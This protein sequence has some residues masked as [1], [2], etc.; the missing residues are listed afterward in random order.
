MLKVNTSG[1]TYQTLKQ[2]F[3]DTLLA[4][5]HYLTCFL[6]FEL[7]H[8]LFCFILLFI[9]FQLLNPGS[10]RPPH[11]RHVDEWVNYY[12]TIH[13][14]FKTVQGYAMNVFEVS[15]NYVLVCGLQK[16]NVFQISTELLFYLYSE[17]TRHFLTM[18]QTIIDPFHNRFRII[19]LL[20]RLDSGKKKIDK[21]AADV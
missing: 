8:I 1:S 3:C 12:I 20:F 15:I 11:K 7:Y 16:L 4:F 13:Y 2:C 14:N 19:R 6:L 10:G 21:A 9:L 17:V 5:W 18:Y